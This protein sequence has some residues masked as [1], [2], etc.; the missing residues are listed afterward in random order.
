MIQYELGHNMVGNK[1][2][3]FDR[4]VFNYGFSTPRGGVFIIPKSGWYNVVVIL[5]SHAGGF[6][7]SVRKNDLINVKFGNGR[8]QT[9]TANTIV[10]CD[11]GNTISA[12]MELPGAG[13]GEAEPHKNIILIRF[14]F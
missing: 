1:R 9:A 3:D 13:I 7:A 10:Y 12:H 11:K 5:S 6:Y 4:Q 14:L 2:I 8:W